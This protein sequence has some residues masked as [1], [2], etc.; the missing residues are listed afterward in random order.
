MKKQMEV[1]HTISWGTTSNPI[2]LEDAI[3]YMLAI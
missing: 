1:L 3:N 2:K